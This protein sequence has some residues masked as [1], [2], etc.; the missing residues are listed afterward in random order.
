MP[1]KPKKTSNERTHRVECVCVCAVLFVNFVVLMLARCWQAKRKQAAI[2]FNQGAKQ[3]NP[4]QTPRIT[5]KSKAAAAEL[6]QIKKTREIFKEK[7]VHNDDKAKKST[8][9]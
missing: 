1:R 2:V 8:T 6:A 5:Q 9:R 4:H 3:E 7:Y